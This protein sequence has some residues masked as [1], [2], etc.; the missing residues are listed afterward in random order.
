MSHMFKNIQC[1][2]LCLGAVPGVFV[3]ALKF[4]SHMLLTRLSLLFHCFKS[5]PWTS[6]NEKKRHFKIEGPG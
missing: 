1:I 5:G 6:D 3:F 2:N 4:K